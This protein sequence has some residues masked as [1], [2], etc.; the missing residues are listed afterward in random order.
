[1]NNPGHLKWILLGVLVGFGASFV[2]G[3]LITLPL[4]LYYLI[5][6]GIVVAF[7]TIYIKKTQLNLKEWFSR[8]WVWGI[9]LGLV[10]GALMVQN[11]LSRPV[12]EKFTGPYLAWLIFWRGLIYGAIDG[13][14][15]S[16]FPWMVTWRAFDVEK[17]PL[18]KKIAFGFLAWFFILVLTTAYHLGYADFRSK[19]MIEPNIGNTII[20]VPTLVSGNPIGSPMVHAIMHITAIIH[21]PKT[22]LFLP[23]HRK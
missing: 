23:P 3:D 5:Y 22:E 7:F 16:V 18:G 13:L 2:F 19:K 20:S 15:L 21:S 14:L 1:M 6:F 10:F 12:T 4:D 11:V 9:L 8:R 17:K